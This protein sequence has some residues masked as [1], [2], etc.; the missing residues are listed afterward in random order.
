MDEQTVTIHYTKHHQAYVDKLNS[1]LRSIR[2][3]KIISLEDLL[4]NLNGLPEELG[5]VI[6]SPMVV[7]ILTIRYFGHCYAKKI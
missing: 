7:G 2:S 3:G 1:G 4:A 5:K 6:K